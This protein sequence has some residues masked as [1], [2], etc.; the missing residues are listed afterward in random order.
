MSEARRSPSDRRRRWRRRL[1]LA[2]LLLGIAAPRLAADPSLVPLDGIWKITAGP[3]RLSAECDIPRGSFS[4]LSEPSQG[5]G[6][7]Y[8]NYYSTFS[9]SGRQIRA[10]SPAEFPDSG[11]WSGTQPPQPVV[12]GLRARNLTNA[13]AAAISP[14]GRRITGV[15][16]EFCIHW[17]DDEL[18]SVEVMEIP[19]LATRVPVA[20]RALD[21]AGQPIAD[22]VQG[23]PFVLE[24]TAS[25]ALEWESFWISRLGPE[26]LQWVSAA[27][28]DGGAR[29]QTGSL[30][31]TAPGAEPPADPVAEAEAGRFQAEAGSVLTF[32]LGRTLARLELLVTSQRMATMKPPKVEELELAVARASLD[33]DIE[34]TLRD[35]A[36]ER[37]QIKRQDTTL[38]AL[39]ESAR[40]KDAAI[41]ALEAQMQALTL[42]RDALAIDRAALPAELRTLLTHRDNLLR[43]KRLSEDRL[44]AAQDRGDTVNRDFEVKTLDSLEKQ[45]AE[46]NL[47]IRA[48]WAAVPES[49]DDSKPTTPAQLERV[50][51]TLQAE[52]DRLR[53]DL[54]EARARRGFDD[55]STTVA[56]EAIAAAEAEIARLEARLAE[57]QAARRRLDRPFGYVQSVDARQGDFVRYEA[58]HEDLQRLQATFDD[59]KNRLQQA[60]ASLFEAERLHWR[61]KQDFLRAAEAVSDADW[62]LLDANWSSLAKQLGV[63]VLA[64]GGELG[65]AALTGGP[66]GLL[67][68]ATSKLAFNLWDI[69]KGQEDVKSFDPSGIARLV[70]QQQANA[71]KQYDA[72]ALLDDDT[73]C[74][75]AAAA[76]AEAQRLSILEPDLFPPGSLYDR[77]GWPVLRE[78][79]SM[80]AKNPATYAAQR[81]ILQQGMNRSLA[82]LDELRRIRADPNSWMDALDP[83]WRDRVD[84]DGVLDA[85]RR[86]L[87]GAADDLARLSSWRTQAAH[88]GLGFLVSA[89]INV[90][91]T[92]AQEWIRS[93]EG[94]AYVAFFEKQMAMT[95]AWRAFMGSSCLRWNELDRVERLQQH[96]NALL[97]AYDL[98][99]GFVIGTNKP[100]DLAAE[101]I[102]SVPVS[103]AGYYPMDLVIAG[104]TGERLDR[105]YRFRFPAGSLAAAPTGQPL[106][107]VIK[108][109]PPE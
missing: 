73:L 11:K 20:L 41:K 92:K 109:K 49:A 68:E 56:R 104:V 43:E 14:D 53:G 62:E 15:D 82:N 91:K 3:S 26:P 94:E 52:L 95:Q 76:G 40:T 101:L 59:V 12:E 85:E 105:S 36:F 66:P 24:I 29:F 46:V 77:Y 42:R 90:G 4:F 51:R 27:P 80:A 55:S 108:V 1:G 45:L 67:I 57:L 30:T 72:D 38:E 61:L 18:Q 39:S 96:Y 7:L 87:Q 9:F 79:L 21:P 71:E 25:Q 2:A 50:R 5:D 107:V 81:E 32:R 10:E 23:Q 33:A 70:A 13:L 22:V 44:L 84:V 35:I 100:I 16:Q 60:R 17:R 63:E 86:A 83:R 75:Y 89:A 34:K 19:I 74:R 99:L 69:H 8:W 103:S 102:V 64:Q 47:R 65:F 98:E 58:T 48:L 31:V 106:S 54:V 37:E 97:K 88:V 78:T 93:G 6:L 28:L